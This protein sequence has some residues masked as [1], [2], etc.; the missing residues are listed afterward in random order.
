[1]RQKIPTTLTQIMGRSFFLY[2]LEVNND[3]AGVIRFGAYDGAGLAIIPM[4]DV[5]PGGVM[6]Y[7]AE[8]GAPVAAGMSWIASA[9]GLVGWYNT[10]VAGHIC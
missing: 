2:W 9:P 4:Q 3:T 8:S 10:S 6:T 7:K 1:M 5:Q